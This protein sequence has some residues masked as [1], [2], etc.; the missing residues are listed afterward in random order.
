MKRKE[1]LKT[2]SIG[3]AVLYA[4]S[5]LISQTEKVP[6]LDK[7]LVQ[8]FVGAGHN[9]LDK[10]KTLYAEQPALVYAAHDLGGGDFETAIEGAGHVG[11]KEIAQFLIEKGAR[12][13][14]FVLT[15]LGKTAIVKS[16]I[17]AFPAY[18]TARGPHGF[19]LLHHAQRGGEDAKE[20]LEYLKMKGLSETRAKL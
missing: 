2:L 9:N 13:N 14:L 3:T 18:L 8:E 15:M 6:P 11:N 17:E 10:V 19:T 5:G 1:F 12:T 20:L 4:P 7:L 16:F